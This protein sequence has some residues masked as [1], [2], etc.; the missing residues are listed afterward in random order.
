M[1]RYC[2]F[3]DSKSPLI[4][5]TSRT[6]T[7][8]HVW[9]CWSRS[10]QIWPTFSAIGAPA[11]RQRLSARRSRS[12]SRARRIDPD[13]FYPG[14][15]SVWKVL[16]W[17]EKI[18]PSQL[19]LST[20]TK[21]Q[22]WQ[23]NPYLISADA[24]LIHWHPLKVL[25]DV[26]ESMVVRLPAHRIMADKRRQNCLKLFLGAEND[27][28][29]AESKGRR[30]EEGEGAWRGGEED[31]AGEKEKY[32]ADVML[33]MLNAQVHVSVE[34]SGGGSQGEQQRGVE[35]GWEEADVRHT[36]DPVKPKTQRLRETDPERL[37][38]R[39]RQRL[40]LNDKL[41]MEE[42]KQMYAH[43]QSGE[44]VVVG[45]EATTTPAVLSPNVSEHSHFQLSASCANV[46]KGLTELL[47]WLTSEIYWQRKKRNV[48]FTAHTAPSGQLPASNLIYYLK[49]PLFVT[50]FVQN[51]KRL[52][53]NLAHSKTFRKPHH[54]VTL[55]GSCLGE[56]GFS[57]AGR[58]S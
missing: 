9:A 8:A 35:T 30:R 33:Q 54:Y 7:V 17:M 25:I 23:F 19:S 24:V 44:L 47:G 50:V 10:E 34:R 39:W 42:D 48:S 6:P 22:R 43:L 18:E 21:L 53:E 46:A 51:S 41:K 13:G 29:T 15:N 26:E 27:P 3:T 2:S 28:D 37:R 55:G 20:L 16:V 52:S 11:G 56:S 38:T 32:W 40:H 12:C 1:F 4:R 5:I 31:E 36:K 14:W 57:W 58:T 49:F 45:G